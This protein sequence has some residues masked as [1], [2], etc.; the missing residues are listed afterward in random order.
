[1][2]TLA[3]E[4]VFK[5]VF[6]TLFI[7]SDKEL[8]DVLKS[9]LNDNDKVF[10][11]KLLDSIETNKDKFL[12]ELDNIAIGYKVNRLYNTD[13]CA[14]LVGMAELVSFPETDLPI[15]IDEAVK[16]CAK[17]STERSTDFV[18]GILAKF[19]KTIGR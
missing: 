7:D 13:K 16:L 4:I 17:Y 18:N 9:E 2:R 1:M 12:T 5:Y 19:A 10:A 11:T 8:F 3:R 6:S 15:I 14:L